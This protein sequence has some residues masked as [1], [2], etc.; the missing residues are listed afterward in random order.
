VTLPNLL[1]AQVNRWMSTRRDKIQSSVGNVRAIKK[2]IVKLEVKENRYNKDY[3][4]ELFSL[5]KLR[6]YTLPIRNQIAVFESQLKKVEQEEN[7][8]GK[9]DCLSRQYFS[10]N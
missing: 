9:V 6:E 1:Q 10:F 7:Q 8:I 4:D 3:G 5:E 2:E